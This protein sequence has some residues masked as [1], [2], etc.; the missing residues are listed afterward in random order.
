MSGKSYYIACD[1]LNLDWKEQDVTAFDSMW[2][3][4]LSLMDIAVA[5]GRDADEVALLVIDRARKGAIH[6]RPNGLFG[7]R[8]PEPVLAV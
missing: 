5:F 7:R 1:E 4:G 8:M 2:N 3:E 6:R